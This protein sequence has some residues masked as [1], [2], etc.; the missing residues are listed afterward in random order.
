MALYR[1]GSM[2]IRAV[3]GYIA[4]ALLGLYWLWVVSSTAPQL[5]RTMRCRGLR[6]RI[7]LIKTAAVVSTSLVVGVIHFWATA[8]WQV[9][10]AVAV[11]IVLAVLLRRAYRRL[12]AAPRHRATLVQ[13]TRKAWKHDD[14][15]VPRRSHSVTAVRNSPS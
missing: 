5:R 13:R 2:D 7:F 12:V 11:A 10:V 1:N 3:T 4:H 6:I 9:I 14:H 8:W 15:E